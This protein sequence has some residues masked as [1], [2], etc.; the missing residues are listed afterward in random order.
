MVALVCQGFGYGFGHDLVQSGLVG[1]TK[2]LV[3]VADDAFWVLDQFV[4]SQDQV[5]GGRM[6]VQIFERVFIP[7]SG[8]VQDLVDIQV[9]LSRIGELAARI[10]DPRDGGRQHVQRVADEIY[11]ARIR[12][13]LGQRFDLGA[14][15]RVLGDEVFRA[16][17]VQ[18]ALQHGLVEPHDAAFMFG[19]KCLVE[20]LVIG[21]L[22][23]EGEQETDE[24]AIP[25]LQVDVLVLFRFEKRDGMNADLAKCIAVEGV[26]QAVE[27]ASQF[28]IYA[29]YELCDLLLRDRGCQVDI[30]DCQAGE[31][32]IA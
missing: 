4:V 20:V 26:Q 24:E 9:S 30:P 5:A 16:G 31:I 10:I 6:R 23:H 18:V 17:S 2:L 32:F 29:R 13:E 12:E 8:K 7:V 11:D 21:Q 27:V 3:K 22:I 25:V 19:R 14:E 15:S 1:I 28:V